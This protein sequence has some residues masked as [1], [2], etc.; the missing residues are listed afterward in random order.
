[1]LHF[2]TYLP[3]LTQHINETNKKSSTLLITWTSLRRFTDS[4]WSTVLWDFFFPSFIFYKKSENSEKCT[5]QFLR[6]QR[7]TLRL[8]SLLDQQSETEGYFIYNHVTRRKQK[9]LKC[10]CLEPEDIWFVLEKPLKF[11]VSTVN[12]LIVSAKCGTYIDL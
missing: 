11:K 9:I 4:N 12:W 7:D 10:E 2:K 1:M 5:S 8:F 3:C 6:A